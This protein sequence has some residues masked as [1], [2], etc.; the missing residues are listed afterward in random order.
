MSITVLWLGHASFKIVAPDAIIYID[1]WKINDAPH[2]ASVVLVSHSHYDHYSPDDV[3]KVAAADTE[4]IASDDVVAK[5]GSGRAI[6]PG[7]TLEFAG[8]KVTAV[9]AYNPNKQFHP[10]AN[11]W[12]GF[13]VEIDGKRIY[14]AGDTDL[15]PEMKALTNIDLALMPVAA[16]YTMNAQEASDAVNEFKPAQ[17]LPYHWGDIVGDDSDAEK[18]KKFAPCQVNLLKPGQSMML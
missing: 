6:K 11:N 16:T 10:Q 15:T 8:G 14:Y 9:S 12:V 1:P 5:H 17:A 4:L 2:D 13:I 7:D 18:F 3:A